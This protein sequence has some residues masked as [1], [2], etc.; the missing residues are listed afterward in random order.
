MQKTKMI[1]TIGPTS[2]SE[3]VL[4]QLIDIGMNAARLNFSHGDHAEHLGR[5]EKIKK[6][7][8]K[9]NKQIAIV[10]DTKGPEIRTGVFKEGK[11]T[12]EEGKEFTVVCGEE[13]EGDV[14]RCS[15]SY[16]DLCNDV[17]VGS[18]ILIDDGLVGLTVDRIE[19]T[20][21]I[22]KVANTGVVGSRKGVNLPGI[23]TNLPALTEKD[24]GDLVFACE[25][26]FDMIAASFI[27]KA[28]DVIAIKKILEQNGAPDIKVISKIENQEGVDN[29][30]KIIKYSDGIMV[31]RGDM[32]VE[33]PLEQVP[34]VQK[35]IIR[36]SKEAGKFV[37]T[38]TQMLDSMMRNPRPTRA[39]ASDVANAIF[40]GTDAIML[41]GETANG[42][43][44]L[45]AASTMSKIA[46]E[47]EKRMDQKNTLK[48]KVIEA[49]SN[50][51]SAISYA[52]CTTAQELNAAALVTATQTGNTARMVSKYRPQ[53][54]VIAVTPSE[55]VARGLALNWGVYPLLAKM[56]Y[57]TDSLIS[58]SVD[59]A[60][61]AGIVKNGDLVVVAAGIPVH[62]S[63]TTNMLKVHIVGDVLV[64]GKGAGHSA[65]YGTAK[66]VTNLKEVEDL[67]EDNDILIVKTLDKE[68]LNVMDRVTG[69]VSETGGLTSH[70]AIECLSRDIPIICG[71]TDAT[72]IIKSGTYITL[73]PDRSVVY[74]GRA[75]VK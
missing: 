12:L 35:E 23:S 37:I 33:I 65:G 9:L 10:L 66:I 40:D 21:V 72:H 13:I 25:N 11:V 3:E 42:K 2:E 39:E 29:I 26:G 19:G 32:G 38:A 6:L 73:D 4:S 7:R 57:S 59:K 24:K 43:Y 51:S 44:P 49:Q 34:L 16:K 27:R 18:T 63:G 71:A 28:S 36:K 62:Y 31:A 20:N 52:A 68:I 58:E 5:V 64:K 17:K 54:P 55:R 67:V 60:V 46:I 41:S 53:A 48:R 15:V 69:I 61:E 75:S 50:V 30:D 47:A 70:V 1:F 8:K 22:C 56:V 74:S 14:T 45:E